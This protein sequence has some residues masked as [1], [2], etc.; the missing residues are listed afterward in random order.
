L[1]IHANFLAKLPL[2]THTKSHSLR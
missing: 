2:K 1:E